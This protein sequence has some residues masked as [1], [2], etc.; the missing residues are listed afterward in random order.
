MSTAYQT[1]TSPLIWQNT[2]AV[3]SA[4][5]IQ[6][7]TFSCRFQ[8]FQNNGSITNKMA[9]QSLRLTNTA[10]GQY[11][12]ASPQIDVSYTLLGQAALVQ[13]FNDLPTLT[14]KTINITG[15]PGATLLTAPERAIATGKGW[16]ITG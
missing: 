6:G 13:L 9:L 3:V 15:C 1:S 16:S 5:Q 10:A 2:T 4:Y 8:R 7:M 11:G 14:T 12:G